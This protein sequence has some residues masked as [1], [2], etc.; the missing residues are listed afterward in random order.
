MTAA[1]LF[2]SAAG[3]GGLAVLLAGAWAWRRQPQADA[4]HALLGACAPAGIALITSV[5]LAPAWLATLHGLATAMIP[6]GLFHLALTFP[7][8]RLRGRRAAA[9]LLLYLPCLVL[10][11]VS[12]LV[13]GDAQASAALHIAAVGALAAGGVAVA[14]ALIAGAARAP[15]IIVRRRSVLA[16]I[17]A[18][19]AALPALVQVARDG[20]LDAAAPT[21]FLF[22]LAVGVAIATA[23]LIEIDDLLRRVVSGA[24]LAVT[25]AATYVATWLAIGALHPDPASVAASP[26]AVGLINLAIVFLVAPL[27]DGARALSDRLLAPAAYDS[28]VHLAAL[29]RG[30]ASARTVE[31]VVTH[32]RDVLGGALAASWAMVY[33]PDGAQR[34]R[35]VGGAGRRA[36]T[37]PAALL[38]PIERGEAVLL[39]DVEELRGALPPP[40]DALDAALL[41]PLRASNQTVG[42]LVLGRRPSR[43]PYTPHDLSFLRTAAYQVA[44]ALLGSAAFDQ[45]E[46][47]NE[48]LARVN[49]RLEEQVAERTAALETRN[50]DLNR[51]LAD[52][53]RTC[54]QLEE[55][56]TGLLRAERLATLGRLTA[57]LA[58]EINTPLGAVLNALKILGDLAREYAAAVDDPQVHPADHRDIARE[59]LATTQSAADWVRKAATYVRGVQSHGRDGRGADAQPFAIRD[60]VEEVRGLVAHRVRAVGCEVEFAE[61]PRGL[62]LIGDRGQLGQVLVNL[63]TNAVDAYE[64]R[65]ITK[66]R[67]ALHAGR[68]ARG[69]VRIRVTDWA[70]GI[71]P[72]ILPRIFEELYTTKGAGRGTGL[73]L[74]IA[75]A[76]IEQGFGGTLDVLT[77]NGSSVFAAD[78][79]AS[80]VA[81]PSPVSVSRPAEGS[82]LRPVAS[83]AAASP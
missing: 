28:E 8:D 46:A 68:N 25:V 15:G 20:R 57:G 47:L 16:L 67:I 4:A 79:P 34:F 71:S 73:G 44:L 7:T 49:A 77:S 33:V 59:M 18:L 72:A 26:A 81:V 80:V 52:V 58:H 60:V 76:L 5:D 30:L 69:G 36:V 75:R 40:W 55:Q 61:E 56:Q 42:L 53:Q 50:A 70:G 21:A 48:R 62:A 32:A 37:V 9:L 2:G 24:V 11:L 45:L 17:G 65:G 22:P 14:A 38:V 35:P 51:S 31:T 82:A 54:R 39:D 12:R 3:A 63:I 64:E 1:A 19:G 66:G 13:M 6:A 23:G 27:R 29:S 74:W 43:R 10:G 41:M 78:V 83:P